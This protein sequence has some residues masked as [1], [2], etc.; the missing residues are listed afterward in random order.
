[1]LKLIEQGD[2]T[3][4]NIFIATRAIIILACWLF[5]SMSCIIDMWSGVSTAKAL[6]EKVSSKGYRRTIAKIGEYV[7]VLIFALMFDMLG[8]LLPFYSLPFASM[9]CAIA[10]LGIECSSVIENSRRKK[11]HAAEVPEMVKRIVK[12]ATAEQ[13]Q[14]VLNKILELTTKTEC[15]NE[16]AT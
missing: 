8:M 14:Q 15:A 7:K 10:I 12:A 9:V 11:S 3:A 2:Y 4:L 6:G 16:S 1:M 5:T 13:G